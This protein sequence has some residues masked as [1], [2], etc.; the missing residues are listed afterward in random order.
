MRLMVL[1]CC[2]LLLASPAAAQSD[3]RSL[4]WE[5]WDVTLE[6]FDLDA[7]RFDV[8][9]IQR[10]AFVGTFR[11]GERAIPKDRLTGITD[12][13]VSQGDQ[14]LQETRCASADNFPP[15]GR[16]CVIDTFTET[17]ISY[18]FTAPIR[19][20]AETLTI[21]YTVSGALRSYPDGDQLW[22]MGVNTDRPAIV[23]ASTI[24]AQ[25]PEGFAP[26]AG[27][28][29]VEVYGAPGDIKVEGT[30]ITAVSTSA[31]RIGEEFSLRVQYPHNPN[32]PA[33]P[34]QAVFDRQQFMIEQREAEAAR[35]AAERAEFERNVLPWINLGIIAGGILLGLG[36]VLVTLTV[37]M[38]KGR[39]PSTG[40]VPEYLTEPPLDVPPAVAG[41]II[42]GV[43]HVRDL[44][45]TLIDLAR[46]GY[47]VIEENQNP[48]TKVMEFTFVRTDKSD[49]DLDP[50][51]RRFLSAVFA[52]G[53]QKRTLKSMRE[54]FFNHIPSLQAALRDRLIALGL[55][56][57]SILGLRR[58]WTGLAFSLLQM[59]VV[60]FVASQILDET[61][62]AYIANAIMVGGIVA[63]VNAAALFIF[64]RF[65]SDMPLTRKGAEAAAKA[66]AFYTYL[67][68]LDKFDGEDKTP[69]QFETYLPYTIA[70][71]FENSWVSRFRHV[72]DM[73]MPTWYY[74]V[75][76]GGVFSGGYQRGQP[77]PWRVY[78]E[79]RKSSGGMGGADIG[80]LF[81]GDAKAGS[82]G[83]GFSL[84][85]M[86]RDLSGGLNSISSGLTGMLNSAS[87]AFISRPAPP[88]R[89]SW[90]ADSGGFDWGS[91][92]STSSGYRSFN[93][94]GRRSGGWSSGGR[95]FSGGGRSSGSSGGGRSRMR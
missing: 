22:W 53:E 38:Q 5:R 76:R 46:R 35:R 9:E 7:N 44:L 82:S 16:F 21:A 8:T 54:S 50:Y 80:G 75:F 2:A 37:Y 30:L 65:V 42:D 58:R 47:L 18:E 74:P 67:E 17:I 73:P 77:H 78:E 63:L 56:D 49:S 15:P 41:T 92:R 61:T 24:T 94:G 87:S 31:I 62:E 68:N 23:R 88:P 39:K 28:D 66:K 81:G 89:A 52:H 12:V 71:G 51:E 3:G 85:T 26:R 79:A 25:M 1:L 45:S 86:S 32:M 59:G 33:P 14:A 48:A 43:T 83:G 60:A 13:R 20:R 90:S 4:V 40:P 29:P 6:N 55:I 93:S 57:P 34:W 27:I 11:G 95:S 19:D 72:E 84:D 70:F 36:G 64:S 91:T 10:I 69:E